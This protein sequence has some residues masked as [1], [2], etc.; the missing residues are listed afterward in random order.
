MS[1]TIVSAPSKP[2]QANAVDNVSSSDT[3]AQDFASLLLGQLAASL[4]ETSLAPPIQADLPV[5]DAS[6]A[7]TAD[8]ASLLAALG[9]VAPQASTQSALPDIAKTDK[10]T[11]DPLTAVQTSVTP[12]KNLKAEGKTES[13]IAEPVLTGTPVT[14]DKAAKFAA[15]PVV[16]VAVEA[17]LP[18]N[19][20]ADPLSNSIPVL[21]NTAP[22]NVSNLP[23]H[24]DIPSLALPTP[25][26]DQNWSADFSQKIVWLAT[27][28]KQ[29]AQ[30]TLNPPQMGPIEISLNMDKGNASVSFASAH[31]EVRDA[32]ETA[33]PRLRE[34]FASAGIELGQTN[35]SAE[36]F[37][38]QGGN[39]EQQQSSSRSM[40]DNAILAGNTA[41]SL[42]TG[43]FSTQQGNGLVDIF[44]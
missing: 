4:P 23:T 6:P 20:S 21:N 36:S 11:A 37:R 24:R 19:I 30:L 43:A 28:D 9:F 41:G 33:L 34:M 1:V 27:N 39:A 42:Q 26:R 5:A 25:I 17:V 10:V 16:A 40:A 29:S 32:I 44:A 7:D 3:F 31:G 38:Q 8:A 14:D 13:L 12:G 18:K 15:A 35:V 2:T 22:N